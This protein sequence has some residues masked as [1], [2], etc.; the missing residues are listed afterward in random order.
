M[1]GIKFTNMENRRG[2]LHAVSGGSHSHDTGSGS[3]CQP[4]RFRWSGGDEMKAIAVNGRYLT[5]P[6][7]GVQRYACELVRAMDEMLGTGELERPDAP[8][9]VL[10]PSK[11]TSAPQFSFMKVR[12][13]GWGTGQLWEQLSLPLFCCSKL[14]FTPCGGSPLLHRDHVF[15][16]PD[17]GVFAT[18][19]AYSLPYRTWYRWHHRCAVRNSRLRLLTVSSFSKQELMCRLHVPE[20][21]IQ[22]VPLG[23]EHVLRAVADPKILERLGV[24]PQSYVLC[25]GSSNPNKNMAALFN[26]FQLL[27]RSVSEM[28]PSACQLVLAGGANTRVFAGDE[29]VHDGIVRTGYLTDGELRGLYENAAC[30]V[31]P[32]LYEGFGLPPLEAMTLGCPVACSHAA[33]LPEVCGDAA[34]FFDPALPDRIAGTLSSLLTD[35][36]LRQTLKGRGKVQAQRFCWREAARATWGALLDAARA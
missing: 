35:P 4:E 9:E 19:E 24:S 11:M 17:A 30:F 10:T 22:V 8:V 14:L 18:P 7:T 36:E 2:G 15:T 33:S 20:E 21:N 32:S 23:R 16:I 26:A 28:H 31:F 3:A 29:S 13:V 27:R 5:Q 6:V 1:R 12:P 34:V 25:V